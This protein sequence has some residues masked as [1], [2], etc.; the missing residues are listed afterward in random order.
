VAIERV[1][2]DDGVRM[3]LSGEL[4]LSDVESV[5]EAIGEALQGGRLVLDLADLTFIDSSGIALLLRTTQKAARLDA[6]FSIANPNEQVLAT[7]RMAGVLE[8]LPI[9]ED[10]R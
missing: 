9:A 8:L 6:R 10:P 3:R 1:A 4:D 7:L 5:R 2:E